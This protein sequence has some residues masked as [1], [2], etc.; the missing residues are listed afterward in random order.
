MIW[1]ATTLSP[2]HLAWYWSDV[3]ASL[4]HNNTK[5]LGPRSDGARVIC[6]MPLHQ[7]KFLH[8]EICR[9]GWAAP[10]EGLARKGHGGNV[11]LRELADATKVCG[12][13]AGTATALPGILCSARSHSNYETSHPSRWLTEA[14]ERPSPTWWAA[15]FSS[16]LPFKGSTV[17]KSG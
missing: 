3:G 14:V 9:R 7:P 2:L 6:S 10:V 8:F 11:A 13:R 16:S 12:R 4:G 17:P 5:H 15:H 1:S